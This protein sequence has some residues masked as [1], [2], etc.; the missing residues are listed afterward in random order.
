[1]TS[2]LR[3]IGA[4]F[5][6]LLS[7][8]VVGAIISVVYLGLAARELGPE[9]FGVIALMHGVIVFLGGIVAFSGWQTLVRFGQVP[10]RE[11][12]IEGV[13]TVFRFTATIEA[14]LGAV[15]IAMAIVIL[16]IAARAGG[17]GEAA[18][19]YA[20][21]YSLVLLAT[22][23]QSP[24]G[25]LQL[26]R[27]FTWLGI[28]SAVMP[29]T[30]LVGT[31]IVIALD[32]GIGGFILA[33]MA[34]GVIEGLTL[35]AMAI[36]LLRKEGVAWP[37]FGRVREAMDRFPGIARYAFV[38]NADYTLIHMMPLAIPLLVG[39]VLGP[40]A[41]GLFALAARA[42]NVLQQPAQ[43]LGQSG[44]EVVADLAT[45]NRWKEL[46]QM[47]VRGIA[48]AIGSG[49]LVAAFFLASGETVMRLFGG[50]EFAAAG[51]I[52]ALVAVARAL[53]ISQPGLA[54]ALAA[55]GRPGLSLT[56]NA[57]TGLLFIPAMVWAMHRYALD[58]AG[59]AM[60][61]Q[62]LVATSLAM[63][64]T[65]RTLSRASKQG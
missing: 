52:L 39:A 56:I 22:A 19:T 18:E 11:G 61:G 5:S 25:L 9:G 41:A 10:L 60:I 35:W 14:A 32:L 31:L 62:A 44:F 33:W 42:T 17:W 51:G 20:P 47:L 3:R 54:A 24:F 12:D 48:L 58:G 50:P 26:Y 15:A 59:Y 37:G 21:W 34:A 13:R 28:H 23:R 63:I 7:G 43:L 1:M 4:N 53:S 6:K 49:L 64:F 57:S 46:Q 45:S 30:R 36:Y 40:A 27:R 16:P 8:K 55:L 2:P 38:S 65:A 29:V